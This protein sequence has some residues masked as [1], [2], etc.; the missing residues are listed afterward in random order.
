MSDLTFVLSDTLA[1]DA[2]EAFATQRNRIQERLPRAEILHIGGTSL[3]G[4]LTT[5]DVDIVVRVDARDFGTAKELLSGLYS[6]LHPEAWTADGAFFEA[7]DEQMHV[8][9]ALT[10]TGSLVDLHHAE[11]WRRIRSDPALVESYNAVK[12]A[13]EGGSIDEYLAAKRLFFQ[14]NF[15]LA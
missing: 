2:L 11:A 1:H 9:F 12:R 7:L 6:D 3:P 8:E 5:G 10:V 15:A 4:L 14:E 13:H